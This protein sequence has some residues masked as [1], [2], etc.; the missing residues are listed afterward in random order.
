MRVRGRNGDRNWRSDTRRQFGRKFRG[1]GLGVPRIPSFGIHWIVSDRPTAPSPFFPF[2]VTFVP[3]TPIFPFS[4]SP[5]SSTLNSCALI[6]CT[7]RHIFPNGRHCQGA[8]LRGRACCRHHLDAR[9]R[10]HNMAR[11]R[12]C[13]R[14]PCLLVA[15]TSRDLAYNWIEVNRVLATER[16]DPHAARM[17]LWAM[18]L[19]AAILPT[20]R[21]SRLHRAHNPNV[22]YQ[23]PVN[24][25]LTGSCIRNPSQVPENI[26]KE[27]RGVSPHSRLGNPT[28]ERV[29]FLQ[30][31]KGDQSNTRASGL[32]TRKRNARPGG[33]TELSPA[34]QRWVG[35]RLEPESRRDGR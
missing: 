34:L 19:T 12:R 28:N 16:I 23:V 20:Q 2:R 30:P 6:I 24:L 14:L 33:P 22:F 26:W 18:H 5:P 17:I 9:T 10:L 27:G 25:L 11:A 15:E 32:P 1:A 3:A 31:R 21:T 35:A 7:C 13:V 8:A 29:G 4:P